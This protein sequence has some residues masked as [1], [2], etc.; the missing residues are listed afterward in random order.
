M[1]EET[2]NSAVPESAP[3]TPPPAQTPPAA[4][5]AASSYPKEQTDKKLIS[6]ILAIL[7]GW[8]G[9]HKFYLGYTVEGVIMLAC[10][11]GGFLLC[12]FPTMA[13][14]SSGSSKASST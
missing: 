9:V 10:G 8:V 11:L 4:Q 3:Q 14:A 13:A 6:G 1:S 12:G 5:P 7:L 2:D